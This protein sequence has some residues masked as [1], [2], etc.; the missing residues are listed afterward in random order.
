MESSKCEVELLL[1]NGQKAETN[2]YIQINKSSE[3]MIYIHEDDDFEMETKTLILK[4]QNFNKSRDDGIYKCV[5]H[6]FHVNMN[7]SKSFAIEKPV[8]IVNHF[9]L[10]V[11][12]SKLT[13]S[14]VLSDDLQSTIN[15]SIDFEAVPP[16]TFLWK[17]RH[18]S[19]GSFDE[20]TPESSDFIPQYSKNNFAF[21]ILN[22]SLEDLGN[23]ILTVSNIAGE[24]EIQVELDIFGN[25]ILIR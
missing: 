12:I 18:S 1:P 25:E 20:E 4:I 5:R 13:A 15:L 16:P 11:S 10:N 6:D 8:T 23:S 24:Q 19:Y 3:T 14:V 2:D 22:P 17:R 7:I 21:E 9:Y